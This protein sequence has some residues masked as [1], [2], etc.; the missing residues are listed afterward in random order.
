MAPIRATFTLDLSTA[1]ETDPVLP[2]S[3]QLEGNYPNPFNPQTTISF[4]LP[5]AAHARLAVYDVLGRQVAVLT[6]GVRPAG[7]HSLSFD[8]TGL[9]SGL[10]LYTLETGSDRLTRPMMLLK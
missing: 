9:P 5:G 10:Y 6:D 2:A 3:V 4:V 7:K 1:A 8:G